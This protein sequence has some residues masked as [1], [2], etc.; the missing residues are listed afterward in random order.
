M[1]PIEQEVRGLTLVTSG[2]NLRP[3]R[4]YILV[5]PGR[6][7]KEVRGAYKGVAPKGFSPMRRY[8]FDVPYSGGTYEFSLFESDIA[9]QLSSLGELLVKTNNVGRT[10]EI[11]NRFTH[12]FE[13][14]AGGKR[15]G[16]KTRKA[17]KTRK[18]TRRR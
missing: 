17:N 14:P 13:V 16:R 5:T 15:R 18:T 3:G 12:I 9:T 6:P 10:Q 2:A 11:V 8:V 1:Y 7:P 4:N